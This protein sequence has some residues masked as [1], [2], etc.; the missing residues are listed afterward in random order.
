MATLSGDYEIEEMKRSISTLINLE[1]FSFVILIFFIN[2]GAFFVTIRQ[3]LERPSL[4]AHVVPI[5]KSVHKVVIMS[6][7]LR[8][9]N[10]PR[11]RRYY[12][13]L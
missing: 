9:K 2:P 6:R 13:T 10:V 7:L 11:F 5:S 4:P 1:F 8:R 3:F 12:L